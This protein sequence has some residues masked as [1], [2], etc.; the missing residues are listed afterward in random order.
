MEAKR[1]P[2]APLVG[3][4]LLVAVPI[5]LPDWM[6]FIVTLAMA[7]FMAV[8]SVAL[9]LRANQVTFG[10]AMFYA[11]GAYTVGF[12]A[13]WFGVRDAVLLVPLGALFGAAVAALVGLVMARYREVFF[14]MLNLA[15]S[16]MLYG[17]FL[18]LYWVTGGTDG[19]SA[20][21]PKFLGYAPSREYLRDFLYYTALG[22]TGVVIYAVYRFLASPLGFYLKAMAD[23]EIRIEYS[24]ESVRHVMYVTYVLSGALGGVGG[25]LAAFTVGHIVPEYSFWIQ[26]GEFVF[27]ALL[28][29][30]GSAVGPLVGSIAFEFI[31][32]YAS[33]YFPNEW[34][35]VLGIIML[36]IILFRPGGLWTIYEGIA[37]RFGR[38]EREVERA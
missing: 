32:T 20:G 2:L 8:L 10:H 17:A 34:Q 12:G 16:M 28:G 30:Y 18:K 33:K 31:R 21:I 26:S 14:A 27:V 24:G 1:L 5:V 25:V 7:K 3:A 22:V 38:R 19:L 9:F 29:G 4:A 13:K 23:N 37:A 11:V 15:F 6:K 35:M 36:A